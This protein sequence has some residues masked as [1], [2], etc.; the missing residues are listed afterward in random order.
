MRR[1]VT[2]HYVVDDDIRP[3]NDGEVL[4]R[5]RQEQQRKK[6]RQPRIVVRRQM[7]QG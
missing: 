7:Q 6:L 4:V 5:E 1:A 3:E 2:R